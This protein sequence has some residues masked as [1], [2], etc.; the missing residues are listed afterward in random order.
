M[1]VVKFGGSSLSD[2]TQLKKVL[3]IVKADTERRFIIVSAPGKRHETDIKVTDLLIQYADAFLANQSTEM[4]ELAIIERYQQI[5][6]EFNLKSALPEIA[7]HIHQLKETKHRDQA[8]VM[9]LFKSSGENCHAM[10]IAELFSAN[11]VPAT[12]VNPND[13]GILVEDLPGEAIIKPVAYTKIKQLKELD[14]VAVIPGFFGYTEEGEIC[15]F[16]RGGSDVT[17]SII[18]A[19]VSADCYENFTDVDAIYAANPG[20]IANCQPITELSFREMR[21]LSYTGF[22]VL[23]DEALMPARQANVPVIIKNTN[24]PEAPGTKISA[25][26]VSHPT[27][28]TGIAGDSG[29][30]SIYISKYL[31]NRQLGFGYDVLKIFKELNLQ[32]DHMPSG[33]D[34][35][36]LIMRQNQL[37]TELENTLISRLTTELELDE[38]KVMHNISMIALVGEGMKNNIGVASRATSALSKKHINLEM[39][40]QGSSEVSILFAIE[41]SHTDEAIKALYHE[42]F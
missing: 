34:D 21:E 35:I 18:A 33:I 38:I 5:S 19:G 23:H 12:Y 16:S 17:G 10:L 32:F 41:D 6:E 28:V 2:A 40:N 8:R 36:T 27:P 37:T 26:K 31:M 1:K 14:T 25:Q 30:T 9:D 4:V 20:L 15:T 3:K 7:S 11:G 42:F 24:N 13:A 22:R 29:F 39:I